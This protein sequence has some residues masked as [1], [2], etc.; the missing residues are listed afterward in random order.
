ML[1]IA[2]VWGAL[3]ISL[4]WKSLVLINYESPL[5]LLGYMKTCKDI[6]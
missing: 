1:F 3:K 5:L 2:S 4:S 6:N